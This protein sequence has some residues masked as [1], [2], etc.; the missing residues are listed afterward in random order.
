MQNIFV[1]A[2]ALFLAL[3]VA[4]GCIRPREIRAVVT[5]HLGGG[6]SGGEAP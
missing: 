3:A 2:I 1:A 5:E 6:G 4:G